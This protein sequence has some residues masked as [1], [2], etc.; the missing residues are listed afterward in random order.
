MSP[1]FTI[2]SKSRILLTRVL[3]EDF[4]VSFLPS[5]SKTFKHSIISFSEWRTSIHILTECKVRSSADEKSKILKQG[6]YPCVVEQL[7][8]FLKL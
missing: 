1:E 8:Q 5:Q 2:K 6:F 7:S 3:L 4:M